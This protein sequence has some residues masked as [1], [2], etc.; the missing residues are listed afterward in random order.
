MSN[1][2]TI[3]LLSSQL[4]LT[5][6]AQSQFSSLYE[7]PGTDANSSPLQTKIQSMFSHTAQIYMNHTG[8]MSVEEFTKHLEQTF[9]TNKVEVEWKECFEIPDDTNHTE[10]S[11]AEGKTGI[12]TGYFIITRTLKFWIRATPAKNYTHVSLSA[13]IANVP[14]ASQGSDESVKTS[15]GGD[16]RRIIQLFYTSVSKAAPVH[17]QGANRT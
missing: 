10:N 2:D 8:P 6:W 13:K 7:H 16:T 11:G 14:D 12:V 15:G 4:T 9:S 17:I 3:S 1:E 5:E